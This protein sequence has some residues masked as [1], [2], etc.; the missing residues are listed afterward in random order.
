M[1]S[2]VAAVSRIMSAMV[3]ALILSS[4]AHATSTFELEEA[5]PVPMFSTIGTPRIAVNVAKLAGGRL[6]ITGHAASAGQVVGIRSTTFKVAADK[7]KRFS[8]NVDFR[9]PDCRIY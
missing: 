5:E 1:N 2:N 9:T 4:P 7:D 8:F 3:S 6:V